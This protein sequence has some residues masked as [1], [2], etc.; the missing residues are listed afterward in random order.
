[1]AA[2]PIS[3]IKTAVAAQNSGFHKEKNKNSLKNFGKVYKRNFCLEIKLD[4]IIA[5]G[6]G[7]S[8]HGPPAV[9][10]VC[11]PL[12]WHQ[13]IV[14]AATKT[15]KQTQDNALRDGEKEKI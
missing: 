1:M 3:P 12:G 14:T 5:R 10:A 15:S 7:R 6:V 11:D 8:S 9:W 2:A 13:N 4:I